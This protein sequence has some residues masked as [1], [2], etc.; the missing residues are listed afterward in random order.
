MNYI[1]LIWTLFHIK[2][3]LNIGIFRSIKF[4]LK[5]IHDSI[6]KKKFVGF[7]VHASLDDESGIITSARTITGNRN[8]GANQEVKDILK[9]DASKNIT[10]EAVCADSLYDSYENRQ[11]IHTQN[12]RAFIPSRT[13]AGKIKTHLENFIYD[14]SKDTLIC[15]EG[16]SPIS[17]TNQEQGTLYIF[18]T[19][20]CKNCPGIHNCP[21][22]NYGRIRAFV[23]NNYRLRLMDDIPAKLEAYVR[24]KGIEGEF[25]EVKKWHGLAR[26]R[27]RQ[28]WRVTIQ[29]FM[30]FSVANIKRIISLLRLKP[31]YV[32][33]QTG[34]G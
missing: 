4:Y 6:F 18:S 2:S 21:A 15:P 29:A 9:E 16:Y 27:Y 26:A 11:Q 1:F 19:T 13:K 17:K 33:C 34:F 14:K 22:P 32:L 12:M 30:T 8:E 7:K 31:E 20:Q 25:G 10:H 24:R 23:S 5:D 3:F 28:R